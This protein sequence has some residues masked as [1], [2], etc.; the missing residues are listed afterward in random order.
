[1]MDRLEQYLLVATGKDKEEISSNNPYKKIGFDGDKRRLGWIRVTPFNLIKDSL[2]GISPL[3]KGKENF[4]FVGMG[5]SINGIKTLFFLWGARHQKI[6]IGGHF[7]RCR[8]FASRISA[9]RP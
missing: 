5:G 9:S 6:V 4:I 3:L 1:M 8:M 7:A 2:L